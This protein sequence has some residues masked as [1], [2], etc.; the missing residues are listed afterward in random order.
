MLSQFQVEGKQSLPPS[1]YSP[2][3]LAFIGDAVYS[4]VI[5]TLI[6]GQGNMQV[7][8]MHRKVSSL[9]KAEAQSK[10]YHVIEPLLNEK[11]Q[12]IF[13]RGRNTRSHTSAKNASIID[14]RVATGVEA[15]VGYLYLSGEME[16]L[17]Y[18]I[19]EGLKG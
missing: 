7:N 2:L 15:L 10:L 19:A 5:R 11:E 4:L 14:Y 3:V 12:E 18:L 6:V 17:L 8:K 1:Q 13:K 16:R 9:V